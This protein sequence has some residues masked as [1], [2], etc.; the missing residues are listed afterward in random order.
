MRGSRTP[1]VI[2]GAGGF[3]REV[4]DVV[5]AINDS[6]T[7]ADR[8]EYA[9]LGFLD[10]GEPEPDLLRQRGAPHLGPT[11]ALVGMRSD[12]QYVIG[13]GNGGTRR[14]IDAWASGRGR[15]AATLIHPRAVVGKRAVSFG[16]GTVVCAN[17]VVTT[18]VRVGRHV[19]LNLGVTVGHDAQLGDYVTLNPNSSI[20]GEV[21]LEDEVTMGTGASVIQGRRIGARATIGAGAAVVRDIDPDVVAVGV[22]ARPLA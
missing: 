2:I 14:R 21:L 8:T 18:N 1:L 10:D 3:G 19:H 6:V 13:I 7:A 17:A 9:F 20:S 5:E 11:E 4:H 15:S 16:A 12:V 22:P